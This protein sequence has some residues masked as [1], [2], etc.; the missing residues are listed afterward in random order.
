MFRKGL[1]DAERFY[2]LQQLV[3][4]MQIRMASQGAAPDDGATLLVAGCD[5]ALTSVNNL[6]WDFPAM[7]RKPW[8]DGWTPE[9]WTVEQAG[10]RERGAEQHCNNDNEPAGS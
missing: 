1:E 2:Q 6:V 3:A 10:R 8:S 7:K 4:Q 5:K 9:G